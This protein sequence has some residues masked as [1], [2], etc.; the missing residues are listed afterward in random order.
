VNGVGYLFDENV[1]PRLYRALKALAPD[2]IAWRIG[3]PGTPPSGTD[4]PTILTW[5][6]AERLILVTNNRASMPMHLADHLASGRHVPGI[7]VLRD[8]M[9]FGEAAEE[10]ALIFGAT[11]PAEHV[12]RLRYLPISR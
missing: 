10:L 8:S 1:D 9:T 7:F 11:E 12:D 6:E 3:A 5:C 2:V 4:D